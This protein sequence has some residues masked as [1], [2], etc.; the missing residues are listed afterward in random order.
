MQGIEG[1]GKN[2]PAQEQWKTGAKTG[3]KTVETMKS[4]AGTQS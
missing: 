3:R 2:R 1:A 4:V